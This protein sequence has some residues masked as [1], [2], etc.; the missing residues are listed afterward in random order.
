[1]LYPLS[2]GGGTSARSSADYS[3]RRS[4]PD[5]AR[6]GASSRAKHPELGSHNPR[7]TPNA[8]L[9]YGA[10]TPQS[11][12][13]PT[14]AP[15]LL[16][17]TFPGDRFR[18]VRTQPAEWKRSVGQVTVSGKLGQTPSPCSPEALSRS[19]STSPGPRAPRVGLTTGT[20]AS[21]DHES[22]DRA[23]T[24]GSRTSLNARQGPPR[25]SGLLVNDRG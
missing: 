8:A 4:P 11:T 14:R 5:Y 22:R 2:Y 6:T 24:S 16:R 23:R 3:A 20:S 12:V 10:P 21:S 9:H 19:C 25:R 15:G 13:S 7:E 18:E 17:P 1:M